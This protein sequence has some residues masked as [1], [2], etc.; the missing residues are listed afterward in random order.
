MGLV[1][2]LGAG[3]AIRADL[4]SIG[5]LSVVGGNVAPLVL[6]DDSH[7][8]APLL[9]YLLALQVVSLALAW[10]GRSPKWWTL[11]GVSLATICLW[12]L[13]PMSRVGE[14]SGRDLTISITF[15]L[16]YAALFH[17]ELV[18][19]SLRP[20]MPG[21][22]RRPEFTVPLPLGTREVLHDRRG[23]GVTFSFFVT[24]AATIAV[25]VFVWDNEPLVRGS[26]TAALGACCLL[27]GVLLPRLQREPAGEAEP[28]SPIPAL[29]TGYRIQAA[30]LLVVAIPVTL[31][32]VWITVAWAVLALAFATA[33]AA[34]NLG[35]SRVAAVLVWMLA[36]ANLGLWTLGAALGGGTAGPMVTWT[37]VLG[38]PLPAYFIL[39]ALMTVAGHVAA[40]LIREDWS[41]ASAAR[42]ALARAEAA[43]QSD[44]DEVS[45]ANEHAPQGSL[46][47]EYERL[48]RHVP[49]PL[50]GV[51]FR[52]LGAI[53]DAMAVLVFVA[54]AFAALPPLGVT[55]ALLAYAWG[56]VAT[57]QVVRSPE[58]QPAGLL[59][60]GVSAVKWLAVDTFDKL[61]NGATALVTYRPVFNP[62]AALGAALAVSG[63]AMLIVP[64]RDSA[65]RRT[66]SLRAAG[67][68]CAI[69]VL[70]WLGTI[71]IGRWYALRVDAV[72]DTPAADDYIRAAQ[73]TISVFWSVYAIAC[74]ALGFAIR[75]AGVR[76]FGLT[77]FA[78]TVV[79][80]F[81]VDLSTAS[82]GYRI[83]S[84]L[85]L[86]LLLLGTSVLYGKLSPVLLKEPLRGDGET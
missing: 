78:L 39:A 33:G 18:L 34:L 82:T 36:V 76:Y 60:I 53:A 17:A 44:L 62:E 61:L 52:T 63:L 72:R 24:A 21:G 11:R 12:M 80:V 1:T 57:G 69:L 9:T 66:R 73:V 22:T 20:A 49:R 40:A 31:S 83:L 27:L 2:L 58:L 23:I 38:Q 84:F 3:V 47:L 86:G 35:V 56:L 32:G 10:W 8:L 43:G 6:G 41:A 85:G 67:G 75:V 45:V 28:P 29:A 79:K 13:Q 70:L 50:A 4:V 54:A 7:R 48:A 64:L 5:V 25:L 74:V 14:L 81:F 42:Q 68:F 15:T 59:L 65:E 46:N 55:F 16:L 30:A 19:S 37:T 77:L 26:W 51:A 71:E